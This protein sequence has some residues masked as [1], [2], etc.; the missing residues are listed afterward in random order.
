MPQ[1]LPSLLALSIILPACLGIRSEP[2]AGRAASSASGIVISEEMIGPSD[3]SLVPVLQRRLS[4]M[5][6]R[7][8]GGCPEITFRGRR[9]IML[10]AN[11]IVYVSGQR[12]ANT[13]VLDALSG[14]DVQSIE[15][16]PNGVAGKPGYQ[17]APGGLILVFLKSGGNTEEGVWGGRLARAPYVDALL[18]QLEKPLPR[19][20]D[21]PGGFVS[22]RGNPIRWV[23]LSEM[24][25]SA[26][27]RVH[28]AL[29]G[30]TD[31]VEPE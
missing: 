4:S 26:Y 20:G 2:A 13:C 23:Q 10:D 5:T 3:V 1:A 24:D 16:Y 11:P 14:Q 28:Q 18:R 30:R 12:A 7:R 15:I 6:V 31:D 19:S 27:R 25:E 8:S 21:R 9:S 22:K 17:S 29:A